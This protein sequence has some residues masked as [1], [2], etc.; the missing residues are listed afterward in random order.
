MTVITEVLLVIRQVTYV[1][2][3]VPRLKVVIE[4]QHLDFDWMVGK[5]DN[6]LQ[7]RCLTSKKVTMNKD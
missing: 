1:V 6:R 4:E 2:Y 3:L 5:P 7:I